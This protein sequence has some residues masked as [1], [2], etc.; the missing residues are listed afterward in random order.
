MVSVRNSCSGYF[1]QP[2]AFQALRYS[3]DY[4]S[5]GWF[6]YREI[7]SVVEDLGVVE[8]HELVS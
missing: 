3:G 6:F 5:G 7:L 8:C 2:L 4:G 1:Q